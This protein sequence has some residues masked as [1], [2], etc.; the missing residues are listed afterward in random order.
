MSDLLAPVL[1]MCMPADSTGSIVLGSYGVG[2]GSTEAF[3]SAAL[4]RGH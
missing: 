4:L 1:Y 2:L 3:L